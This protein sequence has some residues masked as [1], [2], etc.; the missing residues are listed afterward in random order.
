MVNNIKAI[1]TLYK[2]IEFRSQLEAKVALFFDECGI[3]YQYE[4]DNFT[5]GEHASAIGDYLIAM[6]LVKTITG[7]LPEESFVKSF[8]FTIPGDNWQPVKEDVSDE[9]VQIP[10]EVVSVIRNFVDGQ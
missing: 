1:P 10:M 6:I 9:E 8:D 5:D 7:K 4:P 2:G 3:K